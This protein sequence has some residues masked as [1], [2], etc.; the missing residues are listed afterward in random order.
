MARRAGDLQLAHVEAMIERDG[1][2]DGGGTPRPREGDSGAGDCA[3]DEAGDPYTPASSRYPLAPVRIT[4]HR[5]SW[6]PDRAGIP[7]DKAQ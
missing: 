6:I 2:P 1:L 5:A 7:K 4:G 3:R